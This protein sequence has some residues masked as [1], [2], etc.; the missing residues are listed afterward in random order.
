MGVPQEV[1][2]T[3]KALVESGLIRYQTLPAGAAP[4]ALPSDAA[5]A[6][7]AFMANYVQIAAAA[8]VPNPCWLCGISIHTGVVETF[9]GD[10]VIATGAAGFE[11]DLAMFHVVAGIPTA[12]GVSV[13]GPLML[14]YPIKIVGT[15][16]IAANLRKSTAASAAGVSIKLILATAVGT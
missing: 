16:R 15:P 2:S 4:T 13:A 10:I 7:W 3:Y 6:A 8:V 9:S 11:V 5:A 12:V 1:K 14:P